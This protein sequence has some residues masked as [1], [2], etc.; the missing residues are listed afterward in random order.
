MSGR[1]LR[2]WAP[3]AVLIGLGVLLLVGLAVV[4][5][6]AARL[7]ASGTLDDAVVVMAAMAVVFGLIAAG[8]LIELYR[9][10]VAGRRRGPRVTLWEL[11]VGSRPEEKR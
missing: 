6:S 7:W 5:G 4:L 9:L 11:L 1:A 2:A 10:A 8:L 3:F